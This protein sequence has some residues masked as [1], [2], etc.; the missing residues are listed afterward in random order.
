MTNASATLKL[1]D[2]VNHKQWTS[3]NL[4]TKRNISI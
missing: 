3:F 2:D 4:W 1:S